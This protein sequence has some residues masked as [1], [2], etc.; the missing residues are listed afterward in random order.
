[1]HAYKS[2]MHQKECFASFPQITTIEM[3]KLLLHIGQDFYQAI[4]IERKKQ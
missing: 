4:E 2:N 3:F 1:V